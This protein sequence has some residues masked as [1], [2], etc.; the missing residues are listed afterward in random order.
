MEE[1]FKVENK[2]TIKDNQYFD[3]EKAMNIDIKE[4]SPQYVKGRKYIIVYN[5]PKEK[6]ITI[7]K[8][9]FPS[10]GSRKLRN[11]KHIDRDIFDSDNLDGDYTKEIPTKF[12][13]EKDLDEKLLKYPV[14]FEVAKKAGKPELCIFENIPDMFFRVYEY[15]YFPYNVTIQKDSKG[16]NI[17]GI[18]KDDIFLVETIINDRIENSFVN[19]TN[20]ILN[21]R[22]N[23]SIK[24]TL[25]N[26]QFKIIKVS[27]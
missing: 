15:D 16:I 11:I 14:S 25:R 13:L 12:N 9:F 23:Y 7:G 22:G 4:V 1:A 6:I 20:L 21:K 5:F 2:G 18:D 26:N 17:Q 8:S 24:I 27:I 3:I 10:Y 19:T